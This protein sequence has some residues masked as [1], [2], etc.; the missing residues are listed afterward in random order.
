MHKTA[1]LAALLSVSFA[2]ANASDFPA[3]AFGSLSLAGSERLAVY[4]LT[5]PELGAEGL[6]QGVSILQD[7]GILGE[8]GVIADKWISFSPVL[9]YDGNLNGGFSSNTIIAGGLPFLVADE[10][11][12]V[13]GAL[14]GLSAN[15]GLRMNVATDTALDLRV[16]AMGGWAPK[17]DI[18]KVQAGGEACLRRM[19]SSETFLHGC[20]DFIH[21][22]YALGEVNRAGASLGVG[23]SFSSKMGFHDVTLEARRFEYLG[24]NGYS[25]D[26]L[27]LRGVSALSGDFAVFAGGQIGASAGDN[28]VMRSK[29][30]FGLATKIAGRSV[31]ASLSAQRNAGGMFLGE[32]RKDTAYGLRV[33]S[34]LVSDLTATAYYDVNKASHDFYDSKTLGISFEWKV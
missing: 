34:R 26:M 13:S 6:S 1:P 30:E 28:H 9:T 20:L 31:S 19:V 16:S 29:V 11:V 33:S 3:S 15:A 7:M 17:H 22:Y 14:V 10:Y 32:T 18:S 25:H 23:H 2:S 8:P 4:A 24:G 12:S 5:R 27:S 21:A